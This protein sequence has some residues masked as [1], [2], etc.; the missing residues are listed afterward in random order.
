MT[1][2]NHFETKTLPAIIYDMEYISKFYY[3]YF[4]DGSE[5]QRLTRGIMDSSIKAKNK[6][7]ITILYFPLDLII[8]ANN[9]F[10][11]QQS[12]LQALFNEYVTETELTNTDDEYESIRRLAQ[13]LKKRIRPIYVLTENVVL[14]QK[15]KEF[16]IDCINLKD[17]FELT[18]KFNAEL[19]SCD[20][21]HLNHENKQSTSC[22]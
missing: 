11:S 13:R 4:S 17:A 7:G 20:F 10:T 18:N 6:C 15:V 9:N 5:L 16:G 14:Q 3:N 19:D 12:I 8:K 2:K 1:E 22:I 21:I